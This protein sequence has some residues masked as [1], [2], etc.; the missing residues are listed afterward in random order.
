MVINLIVKFCDRKIYLKYRNEKEI[1]EVLTEMDI[2][3]TAGWN[4]INVNNS[5][6]QKIKWRINYIWTNHSY[7]NFVKNNCN[8]NKYIYLLKNKLILV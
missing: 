6:S 2:A 8:Y 1:V 4:E 7:K 3:S 5:N